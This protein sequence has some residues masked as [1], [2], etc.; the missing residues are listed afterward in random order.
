MPSPA[1]PLG[2]GYVSGGAAVKGRRPLFP[3]G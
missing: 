1:F 3:G 2:G